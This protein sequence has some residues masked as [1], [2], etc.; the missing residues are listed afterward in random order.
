MT[1]NEGLSL[2]A[3]TGAAIAVIAG[4]VTWAWDKHNQY[5]IEVLSPI[6]RSAYVTRIRGYREIQCRG[7]LTIEQQIAFD[8]VMADYEALVGRPIGNSP[9]P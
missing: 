2:I 1:L 5:L 4:G 8:E 6:L 9:C 7:A 3:K